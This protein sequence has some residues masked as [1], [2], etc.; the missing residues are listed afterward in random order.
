MSDFEEEYLD[1]LM[2]IESAILAIYRKNPD[3]ADYQVDS[4]LEALG[5]TYA[6]KSRGKP[7]VF[8]KS[9]LAL[10]IY[11]VVKVVCDLNMGDE[12]I[13]NENGLPVHEED[14]ITMDE[15]LA[16]L[17]RLRKSIATW[18]KEAGSRGYLN[19]TNQFIP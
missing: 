2:S 6:G 18:N 4:A 11:Q 10:E 5:R 12:N 15:T 19:Y 1:I 16:C 9:P 14:Q 8:P 13:V 17:K 3:L 7:A